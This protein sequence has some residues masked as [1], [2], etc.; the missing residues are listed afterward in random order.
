LLCS[1]TAAGTNS[2]TGTNLKDCPITIDVHTQL[3]N[4]FSLKNWIQAHRKEID[5]LGKLPLFET[6]KHQMQVI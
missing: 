5:M 6:E 4:P 2:S 1:D 3:H